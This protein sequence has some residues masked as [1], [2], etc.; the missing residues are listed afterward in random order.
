MNPSG[1]PPHCRRDWLFFRLSLILFA[2]VAICAC[3]KKP[4]PPAPISAPPATVQAAPE[5][6]PPAPDAPVQTRPAGSAR[7]GEPA[8]PK[9]VKAAFDK[10]SQSIG[11][12]PGGWQELIEAKLLRSVPLGKDG[13][14][15]DFVEYAQYLA[16]GG[17]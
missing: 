9:E 13:A 8:N 14:P 10:F 5:A 3:R 2:C 7:S 1:F 16:R 4:E 12:P 15:L 6:T 17:K 11:G